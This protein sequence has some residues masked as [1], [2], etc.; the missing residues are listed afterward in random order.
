MHVVM[1]HGYLLRGTGSNIYVANVAKTW[2][3]MNIAVTVV[4][5]DRKAFELDLVDEF[6]LGTDL[7]PDKPPEPG[8]LRV[9]VPDINNL[10]PVY[11]YDE[12]EGYDVKVIPEMSFE[13]IET[14]IQLNV[15]AVKKILEQGVDF[16]FANHV[17]LSPVILKRALEESKIPFKVKVHGSAM[18]FVAAKHP[19]Y[20]HYAY[21]GFENAV[22]II[23]GTTHIK[24]RVLEVFPNAENLKEKIK[25]VPPGMDENLFDLAMD[26][27][28][29][30]KKFLDSVRKEIRENPN[31]RK[32]ISTPE[33]NNFSPEEIHRTLTRLA[34]TYDQ[35]S[36]DADLLDKW[37]PLRIDEPIIIYFGKFLQT[38]GV[39]EL[40]LLT[41]RIFELQPKVRFLFVGFGAY[42]EHLEAIITALKTGNK[43]LADAVA[44]AGNFAV[45]IDVNKFF[46]K[47]T[48]EEASRI[49]ITGILNHNLLSLLL[50]LASI[51]VMPSTFAEAFGMVAV[52]SMAAGVFPIT[53][54]HSGMTDVTDN[55]IKNIPETER[56]V[57]K[58]LDDFFEELPNKIVQ[59]LNFL[60]P[61]GFSEHLWKTQFGKL[62]RNF[63]VKN[64]SWTNIARKLLEIKK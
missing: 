64:Y 37:K 3:S 5:Q 33:I 2:R 51:S 38:K 36:V 43:K 60:Y 44:K 57:C 8:T 41:P 14:H 49:T 61:D 10:L 6:V 46:R 54:Y 4:C 20:K 30:E 58:N 21:E 11:V 42:R 50:P 39:G 22:E 29:N 26:F 23:A 47:L 18:E 13:E 63:A 16:F 28:D 48:E 62:L 40:L 17:L 59:T 19:E 53:N 9:V 1:L 34:N 12:Y 27:Y 25:I 31:G 55:L 7:I 56:L 24:K 35:R 45:N 52:E 15:N 32:N